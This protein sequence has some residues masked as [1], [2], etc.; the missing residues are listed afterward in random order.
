MQLKKLSLLACAL[1]LLL[2]STS[3]NAA[4]QD[5]H[6][7]I[8]SCPNSH[9]C[10]EHPENLMP[11]NVQIIDSNAGQY[12]NDSLTLTYDLGW[13]ASQFSE[14]TNAIIEPVKIDGHRAR[15]LIQ[16][17][18]MALSVPKISD[19][20]RFSMLLEFKGALQLEQGRRIFNS[21]RFTYK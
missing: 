10:F 1:V 14:M 4:E 16:A 9:L 5:Q 11:V 8:E 7:W 15:I 3:P 19:K 20:V 12:H 18:R 21:I 13:Y 6:K 17:N 2:M